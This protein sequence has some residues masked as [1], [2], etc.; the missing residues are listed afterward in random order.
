MSDKPQEQQPDEQK[1]IGEQSATPAPAKDGE[2]NTPDNA[3]PS[4]PSVFDP[5]K[6]QIDDEHP[7]KTMPGSD[8][9]PPD[10]VAGV[11][12]EKK[13]GRG[14]PR[15]NPESPKIDA[16]KRAAH[17]AAARAG[18]IPPPTPEYSTD[19]IVGAGLV[20][21]SLD[22]VR[23]VVSNGEVDKDL[24]GDELLARQQ[25]RSATNDA[26]VQYLDSCGAKLPPWALV[27]VTSMVYIA[28]ALKTPSG[29]EKIGFAW[30]RA[31]KWFKKR[32][33]WGE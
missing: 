1:P 17:D 14:R 29:R 9:P 4:S 10:T 6:I 2:D 19:A 12:A 5:A 16:A 26:W 31:K 8:N 13:R 33:G 27:T 30:E 15:K 24:Q 22:F 3:K 18:A 23:Q 20:M 21:Q 28:P 32:L 25:I 11:D 7:V